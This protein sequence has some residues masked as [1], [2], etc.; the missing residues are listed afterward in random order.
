MASLPPDGWRSGALV[1]LGGIPHL[2]GG[3]E[4]TF[5]DVL[6]RQRCERSARVWRLDQGLPDDPDDDAWEAVDELP[7]GVARSSHAV[8]ALARD[9]IKFCP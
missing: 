8:M 5:D 7:G 1:G 6:D 3:V 2:L 4:C 9:H